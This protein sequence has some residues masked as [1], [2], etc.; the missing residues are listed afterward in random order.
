M[1][2]DGVLGQRV[3]DGAV[4]GVRNGGDPRG[5]THDC[6]LTGCDP[7][8]TGGAI[9]PG[10]A[11]AIKKGLELLVEILGGAHSETLAQID[12][13]VVG[14]RFGDQLATDLA[15]DLVIAVQPRRWR[16]RPGADQQLV[17]ITSRRVVANVKLGGGDLE[18]E[19]VGHA[20]R[21]GERFS[22]QIAPGGIVPVVGMSIDI[23]LRPAHLHRG[24]DKPQPHDARRRLNPTWHD[25]FRSLISPEDTCGCRFGANL[26]AV[27]DRH[28]AFSMNSETTDSSNSLRDT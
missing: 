11:L 20:H 22:A 7:F 2:G 9:S 6:D 26:K 14:A 25:S 27:R 18:V 15:I 5:P 4:R 17:S 3:L 1:G 23:A 28:S 12:Q 21:V 13:C 10:R 24:F 16:R 19:I 8:P